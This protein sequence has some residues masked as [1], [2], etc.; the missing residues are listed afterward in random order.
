MSLVRQ[1]QLCSCPIRLGLWFMTHLFLQT[2]IDAS[3]I[4]AILYVDDMIITYDDVWHK[5]GLQN[6]LSQNFE[7]KDWGTLNYFLALIGCHLIRHHLYHGILHLQSV[8]LEDRLVDIFTKSY[9]PGQL[10]DLISNIKLASP[11]SFWRDISII[12][13]ISYVTVLP[14]LW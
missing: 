7:M 6:F 10:S 13:Y 8:S 12:L 4:F 3:T 14:Y 11:S 2:T 9:S 5:W 1:I